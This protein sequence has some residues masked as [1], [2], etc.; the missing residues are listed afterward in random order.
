MVKNPLANAGDTRD[1]VSIP[2]L[3][4]FPL[5]EEMATYSIFLPG[6]SQG[7]RSL[8]GHSP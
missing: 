3:G 1:T 7:Q 6:E 4:R 2:G 5:E 8:V